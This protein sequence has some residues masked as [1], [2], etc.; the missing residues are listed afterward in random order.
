L[1]QFLAHKKGTGYFVSY[2]FKKEW[3]RQEP[4]T[5]NKHKIV[6]ATTA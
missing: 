3:L 1:V 5:I 6:H 4:P 2:L